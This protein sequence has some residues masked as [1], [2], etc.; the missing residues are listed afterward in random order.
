MTAFIARKTV[1]TAQYVYGGI[2]YDTRRIYQRL[3]KKL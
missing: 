1:R 2:S 3:Y